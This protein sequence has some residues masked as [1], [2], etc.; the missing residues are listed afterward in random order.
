M[1]KAIADIEFV[2][3]KDHLIIREDVVKIFRT[4]EQKSSKTEAGGILLGFVYPGFTEICEATIPGKLD[5][6]GQFFFIR[7]KNG[8]QRKINKAWIKSE[9]SLI[10]LG[11]W[12]THPD[13]NPKP[14]ITDIDM[15]KK[16][17]KET[18]MEIDF[19]YLIIVGRDDTYWVA[20]QNNEK[21][22]ILDRIQKI[23]IN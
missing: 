12:H 19:L 3:D 5:R 17:L 23:W 13:I 1:W 18:E 15:I 20:K 21:I 9:G 10:Y 8:A 11:E 16:Q 4:F 2:S 14:S 7:S 22:T 6:F